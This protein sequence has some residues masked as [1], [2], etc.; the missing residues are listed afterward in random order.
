MRRGVAERNLE[1]RCVEKGW[2]KEDGVVEGGAA[3][4]ADSGCES[5]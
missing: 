2:L 3:R 5:L 4:E 1:G